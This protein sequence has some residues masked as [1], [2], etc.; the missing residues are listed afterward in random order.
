MQVQKEVSHHPGMCV[1]NH[2]GSQNDLVW[3]N[4]AITL[5]AQQLACFPACGGDACRCS[6]PGAG[7]LL[8]SYCYA[9]LPQASKDH[10]FLIKMA[11]QHVHTWL[12]V[13][14]LLLAS[15]ALLGPHA[16]RTA[17]SGGCW[18]PA[19]VELRSKAHGQMWQ[20]VS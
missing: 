10:A 15:T 6:T 9:G 3:T 20:R 7:I 19:R 11:G 12:L 16:A 8:T 2:Q 1:K 17:T 18:R 5:K 14:A 13:A 4:K